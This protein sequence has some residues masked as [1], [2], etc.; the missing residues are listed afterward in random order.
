MQRGRYLIR[1]ALFWLLIVLRCPLASSPNASRSCCC[2]VSYLVMSLLSLARPLISAVGEALCFTTEAHGMDRGRP[3]EPQHHLYNFLSVLKPLLCFLV[4]VSGLKRWSVN[5]SDHLAMQSVPFIVTCCDSLKPFY[6]TLKCL[7]TTLIK[8]CS[9]KQ[10][11]K[12][13][14]N[15]LIVDFLVP[16]SEPSWSAKGFM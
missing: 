14:E 6:H 4:D 11:L 5:F 2:A 3:A 13:G 9:S 8:P 7:E 1:P 12:V 10:I 16:F 15:S